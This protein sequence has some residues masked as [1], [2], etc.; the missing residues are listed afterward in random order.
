M[1]CWN[2]CIGSIQTAIE[3]LVGASLLAIAVSQLGYMETDPPLS[4]A[5][6]LPQLPELFLEMKKPADDRSSAGFFLSLE[7]R[8]L[9][10]LP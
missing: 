7:A 6:S 8:S 10:R 1:R 9:Q 4:R 2:R 5:G 3:S